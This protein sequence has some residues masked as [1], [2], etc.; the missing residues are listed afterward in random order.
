MCL[1]IRFAWLINNIILKIYS[2]NF[3]GFL[4]ESMEKSNYKNKISEK[5]KRP[6]LLKKSSVLQSYGMIFLNN[7]QVEKAAFVNCNS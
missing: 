3:K 2:V 4:P 5:F 7:V 6:F 1:R